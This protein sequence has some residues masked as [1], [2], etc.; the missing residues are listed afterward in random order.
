M[1]GKVIWITTVWDTPENH[2]ELKEL[3]QEQGMQNYKSYYSNGMQGIIGYYVVLSYYQ[4]LT[5]L[6]LILFCQ[7]NLI[8]ENFA[9]F[10]CST[11]GQGDEPDNMK[12]LH[13]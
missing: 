2:F 13:Q 11:T 3:F 8:Q 5:K 4:C 12:V 7:G 1:H 10:V 9:I 6:I